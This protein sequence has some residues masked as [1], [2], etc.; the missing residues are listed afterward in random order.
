MIPIKIVNKQSHELLPEESTFKIVYIDVVH[1]CNMECANCYLPN[2]DYEDVPLE[3]IKQFVDRFNYGVEFRLI[4]GEPTLHKDL[5]KIIKHIN[6]S[7]LDHTVVLITN[8]LK[9]AS[10]KYLKTLVNA[11]LKYIYLSM[12]GFD[13]DVIYEKID[14]MA[15]A[16][17]KMMALKNC[18]REKLIISIGFIVVK[19]LNEHLI[20]LM[21]EYFKS[22]RRVINFEFRNIGQ[23]GRNSVDDTGIDN[24]SYSELENLIL[25]KFDLTNNNVIR[26]DQ[27]STLYRKKSYYVQLHNWTQL[28]NGF[29]KDTNERRG[30]MTEN[31]LVAPFLEH[32]VENEGYY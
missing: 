31:F 2:R 11:G 17:N 16:K 29:D 26:T 4:G 30:R 19:N 9:I 14:N 7:S 23:V 21:K 22:Y 15:C 25:R 6:S 12:N 8:G 13:D 3:K 18:Q 20:D 5:D 24:Y 10:Y 27:Y 1:R 28:P 32:I